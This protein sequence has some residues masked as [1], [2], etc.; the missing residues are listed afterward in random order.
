MPEAS[1]PDRE[2][3]RLRLAA[4]RGPEALK[5]QRRTALVILSAMAVS[6]VARGLHRAGWSEAVESALLSLG[7]AGPVLALM[8][9]WRHVQARKAITDAE[10]ERAGLRA[11][12]CPR[13]TTNVLEGERVCPSC[14]S[15]S[16]LW[17]RVPLLIGVALGT[18][19]LVGLLFAINPE[20]RG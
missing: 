7:G 15:S 12:P 16:H 8:L 2:A 18:L 6:S 17:V 10:I 13:C 3:I 1:A 20:L 19:L 9:W 14:G 4:L 5:Q 11:R